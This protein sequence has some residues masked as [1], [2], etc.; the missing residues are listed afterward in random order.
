[1]ASRFEIIILNTHV[2]F[3]G[4]VQQRS[5]VPAKEDENCEDAQPWVKILNV[6]KCLKNHRE[7]KLHRPSHILIV[8]HLYRWN[9]GR[10]FINLYICGTFHGC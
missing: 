8:K 4:H 5:P 10:Y 3:N 7:V 2:D 6:D 1:M 9:K